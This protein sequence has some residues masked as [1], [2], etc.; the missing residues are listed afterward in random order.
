MRL[1]NNM[2]LSDKAVKVID[3]LNEEIQNAE[4]EE[5]LID[6]S[7]SASP[8]VGIPSAELNEFLD[9]VDETDESA[10]EIASEV[11]AEIVDAAKRGSTVAGSE[12]PAVRAD[13]V[14]A[15]VD[16]WMNQGQPS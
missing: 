12:V 9:A 4:T 13:Q 3:F 11:R 8:V 1:R 6:G 2:V 15:V 5:V 16:G 14:E 10:E 7:G